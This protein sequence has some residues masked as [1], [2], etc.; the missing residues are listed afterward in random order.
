MA[1]AMAAPAAAPKRV[2]M[3]AFEGSDFCSVG[4]DVVTVTGVVMLLTIILRGL[5]SV[6]RPGLAVL[7][8]TSFC[9]V[10]TRLPSATREPVSDGMVFSVSL[11]P[12]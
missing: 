3:N 5:R 8:V 11:F 7:L 1:Y 6:V 4:V 12:R 2:P 9:Q 10:R